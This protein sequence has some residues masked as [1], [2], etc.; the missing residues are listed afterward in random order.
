MNVTFVILAA[1]LGTRMKS[2]RPKV[3]HRAGGLTLVE[4]VI[5]SALGVTSAD[6]IVIVVGHQADAVRS[7]LAPYGVRFATQT[8][9]K[10][11]GHAVLCCQPLLE[12]EPGLV[13]VAYG[14]CPLLTADTFR[15]LVEAQASSQKAAT[16]VA[17]HLEDPTGYG[18]IILDAQGD[19][20]EV[21][22]EKAAAPE[23]RKMKLINSGI[24]CFNA[25]L[26]WNHIGQIT[27]NFA[28]GE[29][30]LTDMPEIFARAG[31]RVAPFYLEDP[32]QLIG[33]NSRVELANV[34]LLLRR[35]KT[36]QLMIAGVTIE[37]PDTVTVDIDVEVGQD[38][39]IEPFVRLLGRTRIGSDCRVGSCSIL[40]DTTLAD[41]VEIDAFTKIENSVVDSGAQIG[42]FARLR[43][44]AHV[45]QNAFIGNFVELK[46]TRLGAGSKA[47]HLS[48]LGDSDIGENVN[49][50][51]GTITCNY[52][53]IRKSKTK[54]GKG[55]FVGSHSTLVA[56]V[57]VGDGAY[58]GAG[59]VITDPVPADALALGRSRQVVKENWAA[60]RRAKAEAA[61]G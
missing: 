34:D 25:R 7:A 17:T 41:G 12:S 11:T 38:T 42:P 28:S 60:E 9:Q 32:A 23:Q 33:I 48:Y 20:V 61:K 52:D 31:H 29:L 15:R 53:G 22:E 18:R 5:R 16:L 26:L 27:P 24:Y 43:P 45:E 21:I 35:R 59:S 58:V 55:S 54:I 56:P 4:H 39:T 8:E 44:E 57:E 10:G 14:D 51:A 46:K 30:Y 1:G 40:R 47:S 6:H 36:E 13:V 37:N 3:L 50:G 19:V 2:K 49:I